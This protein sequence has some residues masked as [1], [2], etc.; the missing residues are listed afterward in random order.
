MEEKINYQKYLQNTLDLLKKRGKS[1]V[2][3]YMLVVVVVLLNH[4]KN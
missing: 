1:H 4:M 2:Y 3:F